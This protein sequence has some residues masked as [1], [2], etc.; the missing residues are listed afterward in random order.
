MGIASEI[1]QIIKQT[2]VTTE[3]MGRYIHVKINRLEQQLR[4]LAKPD[5]CGCDV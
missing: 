1:S 2:G 4:R 5:C 3:R